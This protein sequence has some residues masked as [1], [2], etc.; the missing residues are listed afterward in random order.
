MSPI[1]TYFSVFYASRDVSKERR[2]LILPTTSC[3]VQEHPP[4]S[5]FFLKIQCTDVFRQLELWK[6]GFES[7]WRHGCTSRFSVFVL[8]CPVQ[9]AALR[10]ADPPSEASYQLSVR[11][12]I[13]ELILNGNRPESLILQDKK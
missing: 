6:H 13:S 4:L 11:F 9:V 8:Y 7:Q 10:R 2:R 12:I 5:R 3:L 1:Y